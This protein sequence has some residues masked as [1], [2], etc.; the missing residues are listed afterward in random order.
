MITCVH[1]SNGTLF[2]YK[3]KLVMTSVGKPIELKS[4]HYVK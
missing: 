2:R 1:I 4:L 3:E